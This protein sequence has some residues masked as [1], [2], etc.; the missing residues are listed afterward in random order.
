MH[1]V[2]FNLYP[3]GRSRALTFSYDDGPAEDIRLTDMLRK[4]GLKGSFHLNSARMAPGAAVSLADI[5]TVYAA[6]EVSCHMVNHPFP[7]D[8]P[9]AAVLAQIQEDRRALE[10]A[11]GYVVRGMSYPYG[12]YD[13][14]VIGLLRTAG[15][16]YSRTTKAT[17]AFG[18]PEDFMAWHPT[19]HHNDPR[20]MELAR[21]FVKEGDLAP[22]LF[23]V[24]GHA[25]ELDGDNNWNVVEK[26]AEFMA[27]HADSVWFA[28]NGEI[29]DY[30]NAYRRLE[31]AADGQLIRNPSAL[32]VTIRT[33]TD[34][35]TLSAGT[36]TR[37]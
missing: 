29:M 10:K 32:D 28:T 18:L 30:V 9:D 3:G 15:M 24:W 20:L 8:I 16:E 31:Y 13:G 6:H 27:R 12:N 14:R 17:N 35:V 22:R 5:P 34:F 1:N 36:V 25:Y 4:Y 33:Q 2:L 11:C 19:C 37:I 21:Q 23:Y 7:V 26:L